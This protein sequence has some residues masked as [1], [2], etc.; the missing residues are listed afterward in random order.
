MLASYLPIPAKNK[1]ATL[2]YHKDLN[3]ELYRAI[4]ACNQSDL[5]CPTST[6]R[7]GRRLRTWCQLRLFVSFRRLSSTCSLETRVN[8]PSA[9]SIVCFNGEG[10]QLSLIGE[11]PCARPR[12]ILLLKQLFNHFQQ[13]CFAVDYLS[14]L[15]CLRTQR[16]ASDTHGINTVSSRLR[17]FRC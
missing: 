4:D 1:G 17:P 6:H 3:I 16:R 14:N 11:G 10:S 8:I 2:A 7:V 9:H 5:L 15:L 13:E 12:S